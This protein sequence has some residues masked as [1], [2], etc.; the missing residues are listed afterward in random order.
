MLGLLRR[1]AAVTEVVWVVGNHDGEA[2]AVSHL[3][4]VEVAEEVVVES[5]GRRV[6]FL[7]GHRFDRYI[8][9]YPMASRLADSI[10]RMLQKT[11]RTHAFARRV[12]RR[13]KHFLR[14]TEQ[15]RA[16]AVA[17]AAGTAAWRGSRAGWR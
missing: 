10:Y 7:H 4:G 12:K 15:I 2:E 1:V 3:L 13:S 8:A 5:G 9:R 16:G 11:R 14:S 6:L 17:R